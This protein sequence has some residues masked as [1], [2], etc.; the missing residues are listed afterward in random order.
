MTTNDATR[1]SAEAMPDPIIAAITAYQNGEAAFN[2]HPLG[3]R[4]ANQ[5][6]KE[7]AKA[8][9][10][11]YGPALKVLREWDQPA[12][13]HAGAVA[14]LRMARDEAE[15]MGASD[16]ATNMISAA[17][18]YLEQRSVPPARKQKLDF[19][20]PYPGQY[21]NDDLDS[22]RML[23]TAVVFYLEDGSALASPE[24]Q[25]LFSVLCAAMEKLEIIQVFL[26][27]CECPDIT[28]QYQAARRSWVV[29]KGG[30]K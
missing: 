23:L 10:E 18:G 13:S 7:H 24:V 4:K 14:A 12:A 9:A 29:Q 20:I 15:N 25:S 21:P 19:P 16:I 17:L 2:Q 6:K 1:V 11:T 8:I 26:D 3:A 30:A 27:D 22:A 5:T 28:R